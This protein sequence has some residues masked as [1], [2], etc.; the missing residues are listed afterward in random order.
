MTRNHSQLLQ[1]SRY[2]IVNEKQQYAEL[3]RIHANN[4]DQI[5]NEHPI[6]LSPQQQT[7]DDSEHDDDENDI[8]EQSSFFSFPL[9]K[10]PH[11]I[12]LL[13]EMLEGMALSMLIFLMADLRLLS[14]T[15]R[16][17]LKW[18]SMVLDNDLMLRTTANQVAGLTQHVATK[19]RVDAHDGLS[20]A[21]LMAM[22][23]VETKKTIDAKKQKQKE[24]NNEHSSSNIAL[25]DS[26]LLDTDDDDSSQ[27]GANVEQQDIFSPGV[28]DVAATGRR[29]EI[30][31][32]L[33]AYVTMVAQDM[34]KKVPSIEARRSTLSLLIDPIVPVVEGENE[35]G[36]D[37]DDKVYH[38]MEESIPDE[39]KTYEPPSLDKNEPT[40]SNDLS[41]PFRKMFPR[42][43]HSQESR[44]SNM[45]LGSGNDIESQNVNASPRAHRH[46]FQ[47]MQGSHPANNLFDA[48][49]AAAHQVQENVDR[50]I[51]ELQERRKSIMMTQ[52]QRDQLRVQ[53]TT[54]ALFGMG[55]QQSRVRASVIGTLNQDDLNGDTRRKD[56]MGRN[57]SSDELL[58]IME[59]AVESRVHDKLNF[60]SSFFRPGTICRLMCKSNARVVWIN[61][62]YPM[63]ELTYAI[64][65]D[66]DKKRLLVVFRGAITKQ[67]WSKAMDAEQKRVKNPITEDFE[68]RPST[69]GIYQGF[70]AYLFRVRKDTGT[71]KYD[72]IINLAHQYGISRIGED[73]HLAVTGHSLGAALSTVFSFY[74]STD[75]RFTKNGPVKV[76][77]FGSPMIGCN[78]FA[79]CFRHQEMR[80][81]IMYARFY[82]H[83]DLVAYLPA[84]MTV[85]K[86]GSNYR[87]VGIGIRIP[88]VPRPINLPFGNVYR[89]RWKPSV[90]Y[91][92]KEGF[93]ASY[94]RGISR[95]ALLNAPWFWQT[96][97]MHTIMEMLKRLTEGSVQKDHFSDFELLKQ[98]VENLYRELADFAPVDP[99]KSCV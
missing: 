68:D 5:P 82:N 75:E 49:A 15:G 61:D 69:I 97:R 29:E 76:I 85:T 73:Y 81:K 54:D 60:M 59:R 98:P 16:I 92:G 63:K 26:N 79:D 45:S 62:W 10:S 58:L 12:P 47:S 56:G 31:P 51:Q 48:A 83:N 46:P 88:R 27:N 38:K 30:N 93:W 2:A 50:R 37:R 36:E 72:E 44:E 66:Q 25:D 52:K 32:L 53:E 19:K 65:V 64:A 11:S 34:N 89:R 74:A 4:M 39:K 24:Q 70:H 43:L 67:D 6:K 1:K 77:S 99:A 35:E 28:A 13:D 84:N 17:S 20:P 95:N 94:C 22:V 42:M 40:E 80:G 9:P 33:K 7:S 87:H 21:Q 71:T 3:L 8:D 96:Q 55:E 57:L 86:R 91:I 90:Y 23:L 78:D 14:A 18:E 41:S